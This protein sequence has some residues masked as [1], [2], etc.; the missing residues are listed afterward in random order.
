[1][2]RSA[3]AGMA[4]RGER[5]TVQGHGEGA[6]KQ[7]AG[8]GV[9]PRWL[10]LPWH[11]LG[12]LPTALALLVVLGTFAVVATANRQAVLRDAQER[13]ADLATMLAEHAGRLLDATDLAL[14]EVAELS[15]GRSWDAIARSVEDH[16]RLRRLSDRLDYIAAF[17]LTD[18]TGVPRLTSRAFPAPTILSADREYFI[19]AREGASGL[20]LSRLLRSRYNDTINIVIAQRLADEKNDFRGI[21]QAVIEPR[22]FFDFYQRLG[23]GPGTEIMLVRD[24]AAVIVRHPPLTDEAALT[25]R[26]PHPT[27]PGDYASPADGVVRIGSFRPVSRY[28]LTV[29]IGLDREAVLADWHRATLIQ[30]GYAAAA[31]TALLI[32][33]LATFR[34]G[35]QERRDRAELEHRVDERTRQLQEAVAAREMLLKELNHRVKNNLQLVTSLLQ[36]QAGRSRE[37][38]VDDLVAQTSQRI[39]AIA[40]VHASLYQGERIDRLEVGAYLEELCGRLAASFLEEDQGRATLL[41][42]AQPLWLKVDQ[43]VPLGLIVNELVMNAFKHGFADRDGGTVR[44]ALHALDEG[45][46]RLEVVDDGRGAPA[47]ATGP[48]EERGGIGMRLVDGFARQLGGA[49]RVEPGPGHRVRVDFQPKPVA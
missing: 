8:L 19:K 36:L 4:G 11:L 22:Y 39:A 47:P 31:A 38:A 41:V 9:I 35:E 3:T 49:V 24:D 26:F 32:L 7:A 45:R 27:I 28:P 42:E 44:V 40:E 46:W 5:G 15:A 21:A 43:A 48:V 37:P 16:L 12:L 18:E 10:S 30:G 17:W 14:R 29:G 2:D 20:L 6:A 23:L 13:T 1:M 33:G 34:R 25:L